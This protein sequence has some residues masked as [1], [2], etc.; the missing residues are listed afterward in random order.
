LVVTRSQPVT[1]YDELPVD[2][3]RLD[4]VPVSVPLVPVSELVPVLEPAPV[5]VAPVVPVFSAEPVSALAP[6]PALVPVSPPGLTLPV[7]VLVPMFELLPIPVL[8]SAPMLPLVP[9]VPLV[10]RLLLAPV[11]PLVPMLPGPVVPAVPTL[12]VPYAPAAAEPVEVPVVFDESS[13]LYVLLP[14]F[15]RKRF[16]TFVTPEILS[17]RSSARRFS[18]RVLTVPLSTTSA[19]FT[20]TSISEASR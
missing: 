17:A 19:P 2:F 6:A 16:S 15:T 8:L 9:V 14:C 10:A 1:D 11:L 7:F 18:E 5:P 3:E 12:P 4:L 20:C 13:S